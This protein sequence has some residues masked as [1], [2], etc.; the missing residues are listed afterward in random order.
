MPKATSRTAGKERAMA[1]EALDL[2]K[3]N[4][5][6]QAQ[7]QK[8]C[9]D[10]RIEIRGAQAVTDAKVESLL[11]MQRQQTLTL[12]DIGDV[13]P[14]IKQSYENKKARDRAWKALG[15]FVLGM[16]RKNWDS[17]SG[18][19]IFVV[20]GCYLGWKGVPWADVMKALIHP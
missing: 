2:G 15:D 13:L 1:K 9:L 17:V 5:A 19:L 20:V 4:Q 6:W 16:V 7:H 10:T 3:T 8:E 11:E 14:W 18:K 12:N